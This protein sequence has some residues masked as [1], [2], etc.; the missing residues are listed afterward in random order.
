M[1]VIKPYIGKHD[2][3]SVF[4]N[5]GKYGYYLNY[6]D[7]LYSV[8]QCFQKPKFGLND[9]IKIIDYKNKLNENKKDEDVVNDEGINEVIKNIKNKKSLNKKSNE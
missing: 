5:N 3:S 7:K 9:A 2:G 6:K 1:E 4:L 8:P